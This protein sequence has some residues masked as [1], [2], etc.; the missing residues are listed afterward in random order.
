MSAILLY[1]KPFQNTFKQSNIKPIKQVT[2]LIV[3]VISRG[4][5]RGVNPEG[6]PMLFRVYY[7]WVILMFHRKEKKTDY[8]FKSQDDSCSCVCEHFPLLYKFSQKA[9]STG[10]VF[11][12]L[13]AQSREGL[14]SRF[15]GERKRLTTVAQSKSFYLS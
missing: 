6:S 11:P 5:T 10:T 4:S 14:F 12:P 15:V 3:F 9:A 2:N 7:V 8:K 13:F 1:F